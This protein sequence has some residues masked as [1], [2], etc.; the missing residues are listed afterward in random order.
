MSK[1]VPNDVKEKVRQMYQTTA[2]SL[3][4]IARETNLSVKEV[5]RILAGWRDPDGYKP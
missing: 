3:K 2:K 5:H 4:H 1:E